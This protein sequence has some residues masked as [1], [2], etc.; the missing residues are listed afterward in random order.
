MTTLLLRLSGPLQSWGVSSKFNN[1]TTEME[2]SKSGVIGMLAAAQGRSRDSDV[3]DLASLRFGVRVDQ[4]GTLLRDFHTAHHPENEKLAY[5]TDRY[6]LADAAFLVGLEGD[7]RTLTELDDA[8]KS[9]F[10]PLY[11]G[12]RSCPP[13]GRISLG[14]RECGLEEALA[15][16]PWLASDWYARRQP[17]EVALNMSIDSEDAGSGSLQRDV[18]LSFS[19]TNRRY[20]FRSVGYMPAYVRIPNKRSN[21]FNGTKT[22]H[23][24]FVQ[25]GGE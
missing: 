18:P 16:E 12:R 7:E 8:L 11:L 14:L 10:F 20:T 21:T 19:Q 24:P 22:N 23:D 1:R 5:V 17:P 25:F 6:Y 2:P 4:K 9:P 13:C 15:T 3:N